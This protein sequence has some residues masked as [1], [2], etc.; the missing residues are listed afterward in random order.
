MSPQIAHDF[1][2]LAPTGTARKVYR[3]RADPASIIS[4]NDQMCPAPTSTPMLFSSAP[5]PTIDADLLI[6][7]WFQG[8]TV[9]ALAGLDDSTGGDLG[10]ALASKEFQAKPYEL[11]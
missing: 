2:I 3:A 5:L 10:R 11:L 8:E 9:D 7:P 1:L 6:I 4:D